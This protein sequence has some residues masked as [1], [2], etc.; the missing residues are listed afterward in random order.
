MQS[1]CA[2]V[3]STASK[4]AG[5]HAEHRGEWRIPAAA[6]AGSVSSRSGGPNKSTGDDDDAVTH[7]DAQTSADST[8]AQLRQQV[9][10]V[11]PPLQTSFHSATNAPA[12][13]RSVPA[14]VGIDRIPDVLQVA[15]LEV[16]RDTANAR[17][18]AVEEALARMADIHGAALP[19]MPGDAPLARPA[20]E[21]A[22]LRARAKA[23]EAAE[24]RA[25]NA[26]IEAEDQLCRGSSSCS[27]TSGTA[28]Q[29]AAGGEGAALQEERAAREAA[30]SDLAEARQALLVAAADSGALGAGA[31]GAILAAVAQALGLRDDTAEGEVL[32]SLRA[33]FADARGGEDFCDAVADTL[34]KARGTDPAHLLGT[35]RGIV[36]E[37]TECRREVAHLGD[38]AQRLEREAREAAGA[39][40][41]ARGAL[42][43]AEARADAADQAAHAAK[44]D[45]R[46]LQGRVE[47][48]ER[49]C[50]APALPLCCG[51][52][53]PGGGAHTCQTRVQARRRRCAR[54]ER[55]QRRGRE[56]GGA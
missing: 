41:A 54:I 5:S 3:P 6:A 20:A 55:G 15:E 52:V 56:Q 7:G 47:D 36:E 35:L 9:W 37:L 24:T 34:G 13:R 45:A 43:H 29:S 23:C 49:R 40:D 46:A 44:V 21:L 25:T 16:Q 4:Q 53:H 14:P 1:D 28:V 17:A 2:N 8:Q 19:L 38:R 10:L 32:E 42:C 31:P 33:C 22:V 48:L 50:A 51:A 27:G 26:S 12:S 30:E 18:A 39:E 11:H